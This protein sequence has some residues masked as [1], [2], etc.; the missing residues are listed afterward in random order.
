VS[1]PIEYNGFK[2]VVT[3]VRETREHAPGVA[4]RGWRGRFG[5]WKD[6]GSQPFMGTISRPEPHPD[7]ARRKT[8]RIAKS[9][10]DAES[11]RLRPATPSAL[12]LLARH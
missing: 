3:V 2:V 9:I 4:T 1:A 12:E 10:I 5:F 6:D 8:L 7:E 11:R